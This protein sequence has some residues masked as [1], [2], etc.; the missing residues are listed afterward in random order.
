MSSS[1][2]PSSPVPLYHQIAQAIRDR[3]LSGEL[4]PGQELEPIRRASETWGVNLHTVRHAYTALAREGL[5]ETQRSRR[6]RVRAIPEPMEP[7]AKESF[8][9]FLRRTVETARNAHGV[10]PLEM[11]Q[12]LEAY[13]HDGSEPSPIVYVVECSAWQCAT[14]CDQLRALYDVDARPWPLDSKGPPAPEATTLSTFFHYSDV[15]R[16]WPRHLKQTRFLEIRIDPELEMSI[17]ARRREGARARVVV[18]ETDPVTAE[19]IAADVSSVLPE[20]RFQVEAQTFDDAGA[21]LDGV[22]DQDAVLFAPSMWGAMSEEQRANPRASEARYDFEPEGLS[23]L[24]QELGWRRTGA[25]LAAT[26]GTR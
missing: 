14:H 26:R 18:V 10:G 24:A 8:E 1:I 7:G 13:G 2:D 22:G 6:T 5:V 4:A 3:I 16:L 17:R 20:N 25:A 12:A 15:R 9:V 23:R 19:S 21:A 11:A